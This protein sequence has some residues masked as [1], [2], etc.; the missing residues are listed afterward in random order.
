MKNIFISVA[1]LGIIGCGKK[2]S[3]PS[4]QQTVHKVEPPLASPSPKP[5]TETRNEP[6]FVPPA[7]MEA[8]SACESRVDQAINELGGSFRSCDGTVKTLPSGD[9]VILNFTAKTLVHSSKTGSR[10]I[11]AKFGIGD[12]SFCLDK[13]LRES[14]ASE[15]GMFPIIPIDEDPMPSACKALVYLYDRPMYRPVLGDDVDW[16]SWSPIALKRVSNM[17]RLFEF[18]H[19][20]GLLLGENIVTLQESDPTAICL[21]TTTIEPLDGPLAAQQDLGSRLFQLLKER[22]PLGHNRLATFGVVDPTDPELIFIDAVERFEGFDYK[23]W[24]D[25]FDRMSSDPDFRPDLTPLEINLPAFPKAQAWW[26]QMETCVAERRDIAVTGACV[27]LTSQCGTGKRYQLL[28]SSQELTVREPIG[29]GNTATVFATSNANL[30]QKLFSASD[31]S[32]CPERVH[33]VCSEQSAMRLIEGLEGDCPNVFDASSTPA[34]CGQMSVFMDRIPG[35][36]AEIFLASVSV[37]EVLVFLHNGLLTLKNLHENGFAHNDGHSG[38]WMV[39]RDASAQA[40]AKLIDFGFARPVVDADGRIIRW[41][42]FV[43][44]FK[45]D[46]RNLI[47]ALPAG[48]VERLLNKPP[49]LAFLHNVARIGLYE[50]PD[51]E[52]LTNILFEAL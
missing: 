17:L 24:I 27:D 10:W 2:D 13:V 48:S 3:P 32:A 29:A 51:Y 14:I 41:S 38:N 43:N 36:S 49:F 33:T 28:E 45:N 7:L 23:L 22:F 46:I 25:T 8:V 52:L 21:I 6:L 15:L 12:P 35:S 50:M 31:P 42:F 4:P 26:S 34:I 40:I 39:G 47:G 1:C 30:V 18:F 19:S 9:R 11:I 16:T 44:P 5:Q 37:E 20:R